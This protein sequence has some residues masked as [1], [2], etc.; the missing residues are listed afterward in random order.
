MHKHLK[1]YGITYGEI[2]WHIDP[3]E[4]NSYKQPINCLKICH[5][6]ANS[7]F[8]GKE[9]F[10]YSLKIYIKYCTLP[11]KR[12]YRF[13][14]LKNTNSVNEDSKHV[15]KS[16]VSMDTSMLPVIFFSL[17]I[18]VMINKRATHKIVYLYKLLVISR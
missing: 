18:S 13:S 16:S 7:L 5:C 8:I 12:T 4:K 1:S 3:T 14:F 6:N 11:K 9:F 15:Y 10:F 17:H 2:I